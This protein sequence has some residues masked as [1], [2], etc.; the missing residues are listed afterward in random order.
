MPDYVCMKCGHRKMER[1]STPN[2]APPSDPELLETLVILACWGRLQ[3]MEAIENGMMTHFVSQEAMA[4]YAK[5]KTWWNDLGSE[6]R[7][8]IKRAAARYSMMLEL[9]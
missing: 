1:D 3:E 8:N 2:V 9:A 6:N 5:L 7:N 4:D